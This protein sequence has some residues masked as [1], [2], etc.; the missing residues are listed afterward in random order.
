M[1]LFTKNGF[2]S[3]SAR[4]LGEPLLKHGAKTRSHK[5]RTRGQLATD[6]L[7]LADGD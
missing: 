1:W 6:S 7:F 4:M 5:H 2:Y 3:T